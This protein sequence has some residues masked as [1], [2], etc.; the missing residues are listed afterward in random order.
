MLCIRRIIVFCNRAS[1]RRPG[2]SSLIENVYSCRTINKS[3]IAFPNMSHK[4]TPLPPL[5]S[6]HSMPVHEGL[7]CQE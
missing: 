2:K 5:Q 1:T 6:C 7:W 3:S 4:F